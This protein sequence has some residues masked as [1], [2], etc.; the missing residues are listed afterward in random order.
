MGFIRNITH[1]PTFLR[2]VKGELKKVS[3]SS[4]RDLIAATVVVLVASA[5]L[6]LYIYIVD[7]LFY[8]FVRKFF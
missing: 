7:T 1:F 3:W 6:T 8:F 2:E 5:F 4:R